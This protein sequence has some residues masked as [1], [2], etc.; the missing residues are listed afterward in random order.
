MLWN[1]MYLL[2]ATKLVTWSFWNLVYSYK[3]SI[4][5]MKMLFNIIEKPLIVTNWK[6]NFNMLIC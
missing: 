6:L 5:N 3:L 4:V 2:Q 1:L